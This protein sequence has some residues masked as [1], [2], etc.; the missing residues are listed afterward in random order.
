MRRRSFLATACASVLTAQQRNRP[1]IILIVCDDLGYGDLGCYG[2]QIIQ[3]PNLDRMA[4]DGVR[5]TDFHVTSAVCSPSRAAIMTGRYHQWFGIHGADVPETTNRFGLPPGTMTM[6]K[7]LQQA[8]YYTAHIG[9]WHLGEAPDFPHPLDMGFDHFF[10]LMG[11]RPSSSWIKYARSMNPEMILNKDRPKVYE[12]HVTD[13]Q[14]KGAIDV[15]EKRPKDKPLFMNIWFNAPHEPLAPLANQGELYRHFSKE[16]QVYFQTVTDVDRAVGQIVK[17][18]EEEGIADN[19]LIFFTS[20]NGP[21]AH[22]FEYSRGTSAPLKG[23]KTQVWEGGIRVPA[24][25]RWPGHITAGSISRAVVSTLDLYPTFAAAAEA[26]VSNR[27]ELDGGV[28]LV[29][30]LAK[31]DDLRQRPLFFEYR[32]AQQR[33]VLPQSL[34]LAVR[35]GKWKLFASQDFERAAL[36]DIEFDTAESRD[37]A[38]NYQRVVEELLPLLKK[39]RAAFPIQQRPPG[40]P[41]PPPSLEELEKRYYHN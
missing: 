24:L 13:V 3:T 1:N 38:A 35:R 31:S 19:T 28:D 33:G 21:E 18:L 7:M 8:G 25:M 15:I 10:G 34:P 36:Y 5:F 2:N 14:T 6:G 17:K 41:I 12:G 23:M 40:T 32:A 30:A 29:N 22:T 37:V 27:S 4:R 20:D 39:W 9:K 11:G 26:T 16:E